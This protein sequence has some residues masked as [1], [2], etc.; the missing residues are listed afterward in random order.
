M[1]SIFFMAFIIKHN[2]PINSVNHIGSL[3]RKI[4]PGNDIARKYHCRLIKT[5]EMVAK[6]SAESQIVM[7][8]TLQIQPQTCQFSRFTP[9]MLIY[10]AFP[11]FS[12]WSQILPGFQNMIKCLKNVQICCISKIIAMLCIKII[13]S[14][15]SKLSSE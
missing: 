13:L 11:G 2:L 1:P 14:F 7:I 4:F 8:N 5:S 10:K 12:E 6:F 15:S 3:L 9:A